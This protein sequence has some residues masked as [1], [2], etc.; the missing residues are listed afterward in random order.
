M[1]TDNRYLLNE[2]SLP[3][4][5]VEDRSLNI[6]TLERAEGAFVHLIVTRDSLLPGEDLDSCANRQL[7]ALARQAQGFKEEFRQTIEVGPGGLPGLLMETRFKQQGQQIYQCQT[8]VQFPDGK[9]LIF[10]L[11]NPAPIDDRLREQWRALLAGF[12]PAGQSGEG[13]G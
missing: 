11:N 5:P 8:I 2:G 7:K 6:L 3:I 10:T 12:I 1:I 13:D 9:Q 4:S